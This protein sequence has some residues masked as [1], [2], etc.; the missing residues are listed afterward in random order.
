MVMPPAT[1]RGSFNGFGVLSVFGFA[2]GNVYGILPMSSAKQ[3]SI[4]LMLVHQ[5]RLLLQMQ[6]Q[7]RPSFHLTLPM[8]S[9]WCAFV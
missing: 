2:T 7:M 5:V 6:M 4:Y 9:R 1:R 8:L 3:V